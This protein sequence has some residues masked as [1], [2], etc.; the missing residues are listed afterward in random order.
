MPTILAGGKLLPSILD[1]AAEK[2]LSQLE[3]DKVRLLEQISEK[4]SSKGAELKDWDRLDR[5]SATGALRSELAEG[6][7]QRITEGEDSKKSTAF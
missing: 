2:R 7:L 3:A 5:E 1:P 6:H 4:Q